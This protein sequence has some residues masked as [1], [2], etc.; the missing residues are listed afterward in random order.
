V[1]LFASAF[2]LIL[3]GPV[4]QLSSFMSSGN[5]SISQIDSVKEAGFGAVLN[6]MSGDAGLFVLLCHAVPRLRS[7]HLARVHQDKTSIEK[8]GLKFA[9]LENGRGLDA[10]SNTEFQGKFQFRHSRVKG[11]IQSRSI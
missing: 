5:P 2:N 6:M 10:V 7:F 1:S 3:P 4:V 11:Q 9:H 8:Q